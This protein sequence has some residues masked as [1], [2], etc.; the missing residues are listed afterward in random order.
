MVPQRDRVGMQHPLENSA[1][2]RRHWQWLVKREYPVGSTQEMTAQSQHG[3]KGRG[4]TWCFG[5]QE[6]EIGRKRTHGQR[7]GL[8]P[9]GHLIALLF[10]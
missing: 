8:E 9:E 2:Q 6:T 10:G 7:E 5:R 4:V 1:P 3:D